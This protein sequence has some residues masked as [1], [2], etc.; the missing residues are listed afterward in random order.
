MGETEMKTITLK[1]FKKLNPCWLKNGMEAQLDA[2]GA[3]KERW[4]A[5]DILRL[6][7]E[8]VS[9]ED[10]L[11]AASFLIPDKILH[12]FACRC[13]EE[14]L[15]L[16]PNPDPRSVAVIAAK[17]AWLRGKITNEQLDAA[18]AAARD[19][20]WENQIKILIE[21]VEGTK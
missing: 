9:A 3:R 16:V 4:S 2:I 5:L 12:E 18:R 11:W 6:P 13:A 21:L 7:T 1:A 17:R 15:K 10:R 14:A 20:A 8:E 19:A